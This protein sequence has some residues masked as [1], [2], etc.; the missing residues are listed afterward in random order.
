MWERE[1]GSEAL[2]YN[3]LK[4]AKRCLISKI[5]HNVPCVIPSFAFCPVV[6]KGTCQIKTSPSFGVNSGK[7]KWKCN[8]TDTQR[9]KNMCELPKGNCDPHGSNHLIPPP[10]ALMNVL[11]THTA[12]T[13]CW[14][15]IITPISP[16]AQI[17]ISLS[18]K[19]SCR[20]Y[21]SYCEF[22]FHDNENHPFH[23]NFFIHQQHENR[24]Y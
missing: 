16:A 15:K 24:P 4:Q 18:F 2:D 8:H 3:H 12:D 5:V 22:G 19:N 23:S 6:K 10:A 9:D 7:S 1:R 17:C 11:S 14:L 21:L 20:I 13:Y